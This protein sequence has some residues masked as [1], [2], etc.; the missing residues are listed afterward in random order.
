MSAWAGLPKV[1]RIGPFPVK[2]E[3]VDELD[4]GK[5]WGGFEVDIN[6][7]RLVRKMPAGID[8]DT[9]WHEI[10]HAIYTLSR[11]RPGDDEERIVTVMATWEIK[12]LQDNPKLLAWMTAALHG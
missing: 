6:V 2:I 12:M 5:S 4:N 10:K 11:I 9:L 7:I 3:L 1:I 8:L